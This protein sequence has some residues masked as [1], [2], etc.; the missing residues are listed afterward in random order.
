MNPGQKIFYDFIMERVQEG[1][2][3]EAQA[4]LEESFAR[5]AAG[6]FDREYFREIASKI[7][8]WSSPEQQR[9]CGRPWRISAPDCKQRWKAF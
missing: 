2:A 8:S 6:T 9:K 3:E 4:L 1:K 5:Q 7:L